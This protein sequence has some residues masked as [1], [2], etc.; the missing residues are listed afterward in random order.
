MSDHKV[1]EKK[2]GSPFFENCLS[3]LV[4]QGNVEKL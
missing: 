2:I 3:S 4:K 1:L